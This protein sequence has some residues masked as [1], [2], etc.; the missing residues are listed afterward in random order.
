MWRFAYL[1]V[2]SSSVAARTP[3]PLNAKGEVTDSSLTQILHKRGYDV[4]SAFD[5]VSKVPLLVYAQY[6]KDN[7][8]GILDVYGQEVTP[9]IYE[10]IAGMAAGYRQ[11]MTKAPVN[12]IVQRNGRYGVISHTGKPV[13]PIQYPQ[14]YFN[15]KDPLRYRYYDEN[16]IR[17]EV[18]VN[19]EKY[20]LAPEKD[21]WEAT[22]KPPQPE[23]TLSADG[24][25]YTLVNRW[26]GKVTKVPNKGSVVQNY[27]STVV[28]K[29]AQGKAGL[30]ELNKKAMTIPFAYDEISLL[31]RGCYKVKQ[32]NQY[33]VLDSAG[34]V[35]L[36]LQQQYIDF[37][38]GGISVYRNNK[39]YVYDAQCRPLSDKAFDRT[40]YSGSKGLILVY[41]GKY[42]LMSTTGA[43]LAPFEYERMDVPQDHDLPF[44][45]ILA[46]QNGK[47]AVMDF[48]GK[49]YTDFLYDRVLPESSVFPSSRSLEPVLNGYANQPNMYYYVQTG[50]QWGLLD[51]AFNILIAPSYE[52]FL[53][54]YD[55]GTLYAKKNG[56]W[57]LIDPFKDS[58]LVPLM[59]DAPFEYQHGNYVVYRNSTY[60][61]MNNEGTFLIP[62]QKQ[63]IQTEPVYRGL[64]KVVDY[65]TKTSYF[66][67]YAGR[68]TQ[69]IVRQ[70]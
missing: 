55:R 18:T 24:K 19:G 49:R 36:P 38:S 3:F 23:Q 12:Y 65:A 59:Y 62:L 64:W 31:L 5:T 42:G 10:S 58:V 37:T 7:K 56:K 13:L 57:G 29:D 25:T 22:S 17:W 63:N 32:G 70:P 66:V 67:D 47:Y 9:A 11:T 4:V 52:Y 68:S 60:G 51:N 16:N 48:N 26:T 14:L 27:G 69:P 34:N 21:S 41:E 6:I 30:Y 33:G 53:E 2:L 15:D 40:T 50:Q 46:K 45:I 54:S 43:L 44:S 8:T 28:F 20:R 39:Y 61:L 1:L 35:L